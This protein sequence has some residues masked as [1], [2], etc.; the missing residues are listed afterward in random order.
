MLLR[1]AGELWRHLPA[2]E[3]RQTVGV[4][5]E[6]HLKGSRWR[7]GGRKGFGQRANCA[8][9][10]TAPRRLGDLGVRMMLFLLSRIGRTST[11]PPRDKP[12][13]SRHHLGSVL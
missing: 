10:P 9:S 13:A 4:D 8:R 1:P 2:F 12:E 5:Q 6:A 7:S 3:R 11:T